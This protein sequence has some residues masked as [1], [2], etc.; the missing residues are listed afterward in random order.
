MEKNTEVEMV[1]GGYINGEQV[2]SVAKKLVPHL[3]ELMDLDA[4][5]ARGVIG[6][7]QLVILNYIGEKYY[8]IKDNF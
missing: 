4:R 5:L 2:Q 3:E 6:L 1:I 7:M 8:S